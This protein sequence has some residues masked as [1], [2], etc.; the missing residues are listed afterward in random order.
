MLYLLFTA[1]LG[2]V[3]NVCNGN[4]ECGDGFRGNGEC[5][6]NNGFKGVA[7]ELCDDDIM[8]G[9]LCNQGKSDCSHPP[10]Y[11]IICDII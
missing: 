7:C 1:C 6:C 2:G 9:P 3:N 11:Y 8:Y 5:Q 4:G 10:P